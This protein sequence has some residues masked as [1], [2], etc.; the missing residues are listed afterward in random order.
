M[1]LEVSPA[2]PIARLVV[3]ALSGRTPERSSRRGPYVPPMIGS[4]AVHARVAAGAAS[5]SVDVAHC[6]LLL[7]TLLGGERAEHLERWLA[8]DV[9]VWTP[10]RYTST[11]AELLRDLDDLDVGGDTLTEVVIAVTHADVMSPRVHLEWRLTARFSHPCFVDDDL[12]VEPTGRLVETAG[13][14][15]ATI[16]NGMITAAHCYYDDFALLEQ[17]VSAV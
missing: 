2:R 6:E 11:R 4:E 13:V 1:G 5:E 14:M 7:R 16:D 10:V 3:G 12:L 8:P 17:L 15:I 9:G